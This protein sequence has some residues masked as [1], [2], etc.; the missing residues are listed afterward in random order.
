MCI[1]L[2]LIY[3]IQNEFLIF[4]LLKHFKSIKT[5]KMYVLKVLKE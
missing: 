1:Y 3:F 5:I 2:L 4:V